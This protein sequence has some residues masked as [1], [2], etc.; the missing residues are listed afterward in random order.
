MLQQCWG[1]S[2]CM[3]TRIIVE[4]HYTVCQHSISL[5][6]MTLC[7]FFSVSQY[8][9]DVL[10]VPCLTNS[11][12]VAG[13]SCHQLSGRRLFKLFR[14]VWWM[15]VH[16]L[17]WLRFGFN[18]HKWNPGFTTCYSYDVI[19]KI[20]NV[21]SLWKS[22]SRSEAIL[23]ILCSPVSICGTHLTQNLCQPSLR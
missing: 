12:P 8:T 1:A 2:S 4:E 11:F 15:C 19:K 3:R 20:I 18:V 6:W 16:P 9:S 10:V 13:N 14:P 23:L 21:M 5:F 17:L 22:Q 7:S